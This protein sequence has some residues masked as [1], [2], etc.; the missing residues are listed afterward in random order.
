MKSRLEW[1]LVIGFA[2]SGVSNASCPIELE[3]EGGSYCAE[4]NWGYGFKK[5]RGEFK[6]TEELSP[7]L[8]PMREIPQKWIYSSAQVRVWEPGD[9]SRGGIEI[10]DL[11]IYPYMHMTNGH[12]HSAA[13]R[14]SYNPEEQS[15]SLDQMAFRQ[16]PGCWS[17]RVE[18]EGGEDGSSLLAVVSYANLNEAGKVRQRQLCEQLLPETRL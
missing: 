1:V 3:L 8:V 14:F 11:K 5:V 4:V 7:Y 9:Q 6:I 13:H 2:L 12:H 15:Y 17:L 18:T 16:M 10:P